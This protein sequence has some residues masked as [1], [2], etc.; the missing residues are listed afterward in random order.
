[1]NT[2]LDGLLS[3]LRTAPVHPG[4]AGMEEAVFRRLSARPQVSLAAQFRIGTAAA[5]A[6]VLLGIAS[7]GLA[8]PAGA[9]PTLSPFAPSNPLAPSTLLVGAR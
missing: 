9:S 5:F 2:D 1:M 8:P 6:A 4:L 3:S 7:N